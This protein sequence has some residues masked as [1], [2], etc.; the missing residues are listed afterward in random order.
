[1][2]W[3]RWRLSVG[4]VERAATGTPTGRD[5]FVPLLEAAHARQA[6]GYDALRAAVCV[7]DE[8]A[9]A[10]RARACARL[11]VEAEEGWRRIDHV[12]RRLFLAAATAVY[13]G[14]ATASFV[15]RNDGGVRQLA[16]VTGAADGVLVG[17]LA[18]ALVQAPFHAKGSC[19]SNACVAVSVTVG[20]GSMIAGGVIMGRWAHDLGPAARG[21]LVA[22]GLVP[23][24][25]TTVVWTLD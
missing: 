12:E 21:P 15:N 20:L 14:V 22:A 25:L 8:A 6:V 16:T 4:L 5:G 9:S 10:D 13:A 24:Y 23:F 17:A 3:A 11:P 2:P 1:M 7:P 18:G 19:Q